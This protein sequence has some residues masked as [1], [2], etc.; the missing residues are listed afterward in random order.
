MCLP[1]EPGTGCGENSWL[2]LTLTC[3]LW[4]FKF[5]VESEDNMKQ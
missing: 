5:T 1:K 4:L 2:G 3:L